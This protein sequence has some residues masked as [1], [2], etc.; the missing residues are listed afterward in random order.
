MVF[1]Y[2]WSILQSKSE[3]QA[4]TVVNR[5]SKVEVL[6]MKKGSCNPFGIG[7]WERGNIERKKN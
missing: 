6:G 2:L 4:G 1:V 3:V 5:K 7:G